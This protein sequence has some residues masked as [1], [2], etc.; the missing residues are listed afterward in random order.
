MPPFFENAFRQSITDLKKLGYKYPKAD[1]QEFV[2]LLKENFYQKLP[3][4]DFDGERI[5]F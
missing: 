3:L 2:A 4:N 5:V 1:L